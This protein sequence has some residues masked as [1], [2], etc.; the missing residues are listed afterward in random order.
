MF[1]AIYPKQH[2]KTR[3]QLFWCMS[4]SRAQAQQGE[5]KAR[6]AS[7]IEVCAK[8]QFFSIFGSKHMMFFVVVCLQPLKPLPR[9][10]TPVMTNVVFPFFNVSALDTA[11]FVCKVLSRIDSVL[12]VRLCMQDWNCW[13]QADR[14][15]RQR[16]ENVHDA[17]LTTQA[18][19]LL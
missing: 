12:H 14:S 6:T 11:R 8:A 2:P 15:G 19:R 5:K 16:F 4:T 17:E 9:I 7:S 13:L 10:P 1:S 18:Q 3:V